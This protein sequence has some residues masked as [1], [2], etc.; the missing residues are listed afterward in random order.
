MADASDPPDAFVWPHETFV[1]EGELVV[2][3]TEPCAE[4]SALAE[5]IETPPSASDTFTEKWRVAVADDR[6]APLGALFVLPT[7]SPTGDLWFVT[8]DRYA[9][10]RRSLVLVR[11]GAIVR[12]PAALAGSFVAAAPDGRVFTGREGTLLQLRAVETPGGTEIERQSVRLGELHPDAAPSV[13]RQGGVVLGPGGMVYAAGV[14]EQSVFGICGS[15][16]PPRV[17]WE[18]HFAVHPNL[19][20]ASTVGHGMFVNPRGLHVQ[21]QTDT[22]RLDEARYGVERLRFVLGRDGTVVEAPEPERS[23]QVVGVLGEGLLEREASPAAGATT[24]LL[25]WSGETVWTVP[26]PAFAA[27][28]RVLPNGEVWS[29]LDSLVVERR[30]GSGTLLDAD[31]AFSGWGGLVDSESRFLA[32]DREPVRRITVEHVTD[33]SS[34]DVLSGRTYPPTFLPVELTGNA[35]ILGPDGTVYVA[36]GDEVV[37]LQ[38]NS[39][40]PGLNTC[41]NSGCNWR[42]DGWV[43]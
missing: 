37:A 29:Q 7:L 10:E 11:D 41:V 40:P 34:T 32:I 30:D 23:H 19:T 28:A 39:L 5:P 3:S 35:S 26:R 17:M 43:R 1:A 24:S 16:S 18:R 31:A 20:Y 38:T 9:P 12:S 13:L 27:H 15:E 42:R 25:R 14:D 4:W 21:T 8:L 33:G 22:W 36:T 6:A 2:R